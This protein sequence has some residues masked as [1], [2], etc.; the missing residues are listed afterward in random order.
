MF[1]HPVQEALSERLKEQQELERKLAKMGKQLDHFERA[2]RE[3][4]VPY[5]M[6]AHEQRM[7]EDKVFG[8]TAG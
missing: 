1:P 6:Q 8:C 5:I 2:R 4:E 7:T 3:E